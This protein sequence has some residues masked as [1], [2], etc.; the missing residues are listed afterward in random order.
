MKH[1]K[2][3]KI[4]AAVCV[5]LLFTSIF[6]FFYLHLP[7]LKDGYLNAGDDHVHVAYANETRRIWEEEEQLMGWSR[8][9]AMGAPIFLMRPPGFYFFTNALYFLSGIKIEQALKLLVLFGFCLFPLSVYTGARMLGMDQ[10]PATISGLLSP[11]CIS[12]WGHTIDAYQ[13]L[14]IHKQLIAILVFPIAVG[15][16]WQVLKN[17]RYGCLFAVLF[18]V[19]FMTHPYIA[20]CYAML[21]VLMILALYA[22]EPGWHAKSGIS[23]AIMWAVPGVLFTALW[24][25]PFMT[26]GEIQLIDPYLSR[27]YYFEVTGCTAAE[28]LR[29]YFLGGILDTSFYSGVFGGTQWPSGNEWGWLDNSQWPRFPILTLL[30]FAGCLMAAIS[31]KAAQRSFLGLSFLLSFMLIAGPDDY[32]ILDWIP[33]AKKFQNIHAIFM[34]EWAAVMLGGMALYGLF[35]KVKSMRQGIFR[36]ALFGCIGAVVVFGFSTAY[37]ERTKVA[38]RL[39]DVRKVYTRNG[40]LVLKKGMNP[41]WMTFNRVVKYINDDSMEGNIAAFP[42]G[43]EDSVLY[44]L[45]PLMV[46]RSVSITGFETM[47]GVYYLMLHRF[48]TDLRDNYYLQKMFNIRFVINNP[49]LRELPMKW[50]PQTEKVYEDRFWELVKVKG[51]FGKLESIPLHMVGFVGGEREWQDLTE[52]WLKQVRKN[53]LELPWVVNFTNAGINDEDLKAIK[54]YLSFVICSDKRIIPDVISDVPVKSWQDLDS[55]GMDHRIFQEKTVWKSALH[56]AENGFFYKT[57]RDDRKTAVYDVHTE[58]P[59]TAILFKQAFYRGWQARIDGENTAIYRISPG[60]QMVLVPKGEHVLQWA[61]TGPNNWWLAKLMCG[62]GL[63]AACLLQVWQTCYTRPATQHHER[64]AITGRIGQKAGRWAVRTIWGGFFVIICFQVISEAGYKKPVIIHPK[65]GQ[66]LDQ[67]KRR[68]F[69][70]YV[71]G[72]PVKK[73]VF[74]IQIAEDKGFEKIV[75]SEIVQENEYRVKL[76][77]EK[78]IYFYRLRLLLDGKTFR[79]R[80]PE[81]L[82]M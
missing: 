8:L 24:L 19:M 1:K 76:E 2:R 10:I 72:V 56:A 68:I 14:G 17:R 12:M 9:Y 4:T 27:R 79:W 71:A 57:V 63:L 36:A 61:Y 51:E 53:G 18:A 66:V 65:N 70:N 52:R 40:E 62:I 28:T 26:S 73:Q 41:Q 67:N 43:H 75:R 6:W 31:P 69:W 47:G 20:Y 15:A 55:T 44:N 37:F 82:I 33:F 13:F 42:Q 49:Y 34:F 74:E 32:F 5:L 25:I 59:L 22:Y 38:K 46:N 7:S 23:H 54:P 60:L 16:L 78:N 64:V 30:S 77:D 58:K 39:I 29:Q 80:G 3:E 21:S 48:R 45:M 81:K 11:L 35:M 50:H